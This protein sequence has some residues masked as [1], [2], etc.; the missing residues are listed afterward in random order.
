VYNIKRI[1]SNF[2]NMSNNDSG[3]QD[4][5]IKTAT[6]VPPLTRD[7]D[8]DDEEPFDPETLLGEAAGSN[9]DP[10]LYKYR[11][12]GHV[13]KDDEELGAEVPAPTQN[14]RGNSES[15]I[16]VQKFPV[17]LYAILAQKEFQDII[18]WMPHGR[19]WKV[20]KPSLF[21]SLVM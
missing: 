13:A 3:S 2:S 10:T 6:S 4:E 20:L 8:D 18:C 11:D 15:S 7:A 16:R 19:S 14:G 17:K 1:A 5:R 12:F 21:E 9:T